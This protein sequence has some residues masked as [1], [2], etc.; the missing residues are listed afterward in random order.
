MFY[1][2]FVNTNLLLTIIF[3]Q[4]RLDSIAV[5]PDMVLLPQVTLLS[6][7]KHRSTI[8]KRAFEVLH[9]IYKQLY[10]GVHNPKNQY[11]NPQSIL[12]CSP[13]DLKKMFDI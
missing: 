11:Q 8:Q 5:M 10:E 13:D 12:S 9:A 2:F 4:T 3:L 7:S 6:S 1:Q